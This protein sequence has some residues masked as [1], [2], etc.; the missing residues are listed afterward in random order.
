MGAK[1]A[2]HVLDGWLDP[3]L[4]ANFDEVAKYKDLAG[5]TFINEDLAKFGQGEQSKIFNGQI[6]S[7]MLAGAARNQGARDIQSLKASQRL[8]SAAMSRGGNNAASAG[9][10]LMYDRM[11][12][13]ET[14]RVNDRTADQVVSG[15]PGYTNAAAGWAEAGN[16]GRATQ[17]QMG[18]AY[19][20]MFGNAV[21]MRQSNQ[22]FEKKKSFWDKFKEGLGVAGQI[23]GIAGTLMTGIPMSGMGGGKGGGGGSPA[24]VGAASRSGG[25]GQYY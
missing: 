10:N 25:Y 17:M 23:A 13:N 21:Q 5:K 9:V 6:G 24:M 19:Q 11:L 12:K 3:K 8:G 20:N 7:T 15:L 18:S 16:H 14:G 4:T 1:Y 22:T 2:Q